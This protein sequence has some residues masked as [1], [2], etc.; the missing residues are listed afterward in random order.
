MATDLTR[1][2]YGAGSH[3]PLADVGEMP[4]CY[5]IK[6]N[7]DSMLYHRPD[8]QNFGA[9]V[10]EVW[11][12]GPSAAEAVGFV[13]APR[14]SADGVSADYEPGGS[15]HPCPVVAVNANRTGVIGR[16]AIASGGFALVAGY[17]SG[18]QGP[19]VVAAEAAEAAEITAATGGADLGDPEVSDG[20]GGTSFED[21]GA[22]WV[23]Y[24]AKWW[25]LILIVLGLL[26]LFR[27]L[28]A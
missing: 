20:D 12:D 17:A 22:R 19:E 15:G 24:F 13:L 27:V 1:H 9:T 16:A 14:H 2:P 5:P 26:I 3:A 23:G 28:R 25:W 7:V 8:S 4:A 6:G 11:F 21:A 10:A 18:G